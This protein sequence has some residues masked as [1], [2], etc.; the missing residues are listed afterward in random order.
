MNQA[1]AKLLGQL[2]DAQRRALISLLADDDSSVYQTVRQKLLSY[3]SEVVDWVK[4]ETLSDN[5]VLRR[6]AL[7]IQDYFGKQD[8]DEK[9]LRFC[10]SQGEEFDI[11]QGALLLARTQYPRI[12]PVGYTALM[13]DF[14]S[15]LRERLDLN[16]PAEYILHVVNDYLFDEL[17][18]T[19]NEKDYYDPENSYLNRVLDRRTG[20]PI[21]I[22]LTYLLI[23][24]RLRLPMAGIGLP[25]HF[26]CRYQN[27]RYEIYVDAFNKGK[28]LNRADCIKYLM[29][30]RH[31][32][33]ETYLAPVTP[34]RILLRMCANLHQIYTQTKA[35]ADSER[36][37]KY[38]VALANTALKPA[39]LPPV[40]AQA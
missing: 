38:L 10:H 12:N 31:R 7:E 33:D 2:G 25:G 20:N 28:S 6:R 35:T 23:T 8:A 36:L 22:C 15:E 32:L 34:R 37:Q 30:I 16:G 26:L 5:P 14:A 1:Q 13:D 40:K 19:G 18:F 9:F 21:S 39:A 17:K 24:K 4:P 29:K 3:G 27:S 11:E